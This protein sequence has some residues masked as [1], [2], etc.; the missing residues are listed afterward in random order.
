MAKK[1][2]FIE[3]DEELVEL[4]VLL[5]KSLAKKL[6]KFEDVFCASVEDMLLLESHKLLRRFMNVGKGIE[7]KFLYLDCETTGLDADKH[8]VI[9]VACI[10]TKG[11]NIISAKEVDR[12]NLRFNPISIGCEVSK[13]ALEVNGIKKK[14]IKTF[15]TDSFKKLIKFFEKHINKYDKE[16]KFVVIG[17]NVKFD[18][19]MLHGWARRENFDFMGSFVDWRVIDTLSIARLESS[20]GKIN[21]ENFQLATLCKEYGI[22]EPDHDAMDDITATKHLLEQMIKG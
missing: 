2:K 15:P 16:D 19:E 3:P 5:P 4:K 6:R 7:K 21:P 13:E 22:E 11:E 8:G 1:N 20:L 10:V 9:Q 18:V 14:E 12:L 17:Q